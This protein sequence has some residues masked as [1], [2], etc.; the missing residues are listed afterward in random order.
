M[1]ALQYYIID[2]FIKDQKP[3][4]HE[5]I[6]SEDGDDEYNGEDWQPHSSEDGGATSETGL[7]E[8]ATKDGTEVKIREDKAKPKP[9]GDPRKEDEYD[10][11]R[12]AEASGRSSESDG[13]RSLSKDQSTKVR[14]RQAKR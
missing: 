11:T 1:N 7:L 6:P 13:P 5:P 12:D 4:D 10:A 3:T 8:E 2:S 14:G 9:K